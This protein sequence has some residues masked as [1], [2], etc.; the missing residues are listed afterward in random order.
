MIEKLY[1]LYQ[2]TYIW[3]SLPVLS[4]LGLQTVEASSRMS[5][6][7]LLWVTGSAIYNLCSARWLQSFLSGADHSMVNQDDHLALGL[8]PGEALSEWGK[9][10]HYQAFTLSSRIYA[11][12]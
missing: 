4:C 12:N 1:Q 8:L 3:Q 5:N 10:C 11:G 2:P 7:Q 9:L 6:S